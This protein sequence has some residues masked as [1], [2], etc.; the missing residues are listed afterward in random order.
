M[1]RAKVDLSAMARSIAMKLQKDDPSRRVTFVIQDG[2]TIDGD[3]RLLL[4]VMENL[5][6]NA[7]KYTST[8]D[9][10]RIE[11]GCSQ[12]N[13]RQAYFV[14]DDGVGFDPRHA[15]RLFKAFQRLHSAEEF[16]GTGVGLATVQRIIHRHGGEIWAVAGVEN[17][18]TF[19]F[20]VER[21]LSP[22]N[23]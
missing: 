1:R 16:P 21:R 7:W 23:R 20:V 11:F 5:L 3:S 17:G 8:H 15:G 14:R 4:V 2:L 18:A 10:A 12:Q 22:G 9:Q 6:G 19:Y 13:G